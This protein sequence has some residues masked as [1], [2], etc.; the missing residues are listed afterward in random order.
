MTSERKISKK[1]AIQLLLIL[2]LCVGSVIFFSI[3]G[4]LLTVM[5]YGIDLSSMYDYT[6]PNTIA[7]LKMMQLMSAIGLFLVPPILYGVIVSKNPAKNLGLKVLSK[8]VNYLLVLIL[9]VVSTPA[10]SWVIY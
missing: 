10:L 2:S 3:I 9:M 4:V 8:P 5:L 1:P 7:G 6:D